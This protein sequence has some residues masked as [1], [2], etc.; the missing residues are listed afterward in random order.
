MGVAAMRESIDT[1]PRGCLP[2]TE[3]HLR[4]LC[5]APDKQPDDPA[6]GAPRLVT[7]GPTALVLGPQYF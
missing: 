6:L 4:L 1:E 3:P 7:M 2:L 5:D